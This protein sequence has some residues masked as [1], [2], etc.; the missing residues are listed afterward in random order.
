[1]KRV[2]Q[3]KTLFLSAL[4]CAIGFGAK[5]QIADATN[6]MPCD[7][8]V[9]FYAIDPITCA[10]LATDPGPY[11]IPSGAGPLFLPAAWVPGPPVTQYFIVA[12]V[13]YAACGFPGVLVGSGGICGYVPTAP[14]PP[15]PPCK[16]GVVDNPG[17]I[18]PPGSGG[19][20]YPLNVHP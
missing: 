10:T 2:F 8:V 6:N 14:I 16:N 19:V 5:A 20:H 13:A 12:E 18:F 17:P 11:I 4:L 15:C 7:V 1:M 9:R 3:M